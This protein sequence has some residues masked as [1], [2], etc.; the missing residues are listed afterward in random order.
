[1]RRLLVSS[2]LVWL[3]FLSLFVF[4]SFGNTSLLHI[5][6]HTLALGLLVPAVVLVLRC[7]RAA[8]TRTTRILAGVLAVLLPLGTLG[9]GVELAIAV[10]RYAADGFADLDTSDLFAHGP[11]AAV[12]TTPPRRCSRACWSSRRG[13]SPPPC[14]AVAG[15]RGSRAVARRSRRAPSGRERPVTH[16]PTRTGHR[17]GTRQAARPRER[18]C[19]GP[20]SVARGRPRGRA[21]RAGRPAS[22]SRRPRRCPATRPRAGSRR[23]PRPPRTRPAA[24]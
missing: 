21:P 6:H 9:H 20:V 14:R 17:A 4:A 13:P 1:M 3:P 2:A 11:H 19:S 5:A 8:S 18:A 15:P 24:R 7:R 12:E 23:S 22:R 16:G 10:G